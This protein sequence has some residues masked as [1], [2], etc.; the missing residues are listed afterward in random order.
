MGFPQTSPMIFD[1]HKTD[2]TGQRRI[3]LG[4]VEPTVHMHISLII[5][6]PL[7]ALRRTYINRNEIHRQHRRDHKETDCAARL[8]TPR[9]LIHNDQPGKDHH[10]AQNLPTCHA[11]TQMKHNYSLSPLIFHINTLLSL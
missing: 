1:D 11:A 8:G 4:I 7:Y 9:D 10:P 6:R 5:Q 2:T 3:E